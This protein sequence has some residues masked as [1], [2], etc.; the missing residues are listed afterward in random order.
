MGAE[1]AQAQKST[2]VVLPAML[3]CQPVNWM[4]DKPPQ[5][6]VVPRKPVLPVAPKNIHTYLALAANTKNPNSV[7]IPLSVAPPIR[8]DTKKIDGKKVCK[9]RKDKPVKSKKNH[10]GKIHVDEQCCLDP[11]EIPNP[12]CYYPQLGK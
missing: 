1:Y 3:S 7:R 9:H 4:H 12:R 10:K 8:S 5:V 11:D 2:C 6:S